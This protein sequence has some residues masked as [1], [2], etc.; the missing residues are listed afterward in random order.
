MSAAEGLQPAPFYQLRLIVA[1][2]TPRSR[3]AIEN[4]RIVC[5]RYMKGQV[6]LEIIDIHQ[7]PEMAQKYQIVALP[8]LIKL[9]PL[10]VRRIIGDLSEQDRVIRGLELVVQ[11]VANDHVGARRPD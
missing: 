5:D 2:G 4:L 10:P 8:T 1:G 9:L 6:D 3:R 7:Q 11:P